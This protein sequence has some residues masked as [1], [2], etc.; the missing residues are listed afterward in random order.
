[1]NSPGFEY[2]SLYSSLMDIKNKE[3]FGRFYKSSKIYFTSKTL[4]TAIQ[5]QSFETIRYFVGPSGWWM[6]ANTLISTA[7]AVTC[8]NPLEVLIT[9]YALVDTTRKKIVFGTIVKN[10]FQREGISGFFKGY[11]T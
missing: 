6:L 2:T 3:G 1:M 4:F 7:L 9:R 10:I 5:F 8:V 11:G